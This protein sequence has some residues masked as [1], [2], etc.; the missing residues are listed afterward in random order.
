M[1]HEKKY[2][3]IQALLAFA[4]LCKR[5]QQDFITTMNLLLRSSPQRRREIIDQLKAEAAKGWSYRRVEPPV[6]E[7]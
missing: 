7:P 5:E 4:S 3:T 6:E 2:T 1:L